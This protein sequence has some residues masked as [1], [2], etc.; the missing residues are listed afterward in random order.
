MVKSRLA[1]GSPTGCPKKNAPINNNS[2]NDNNDNNNNNNDYKNQHYS[3]LVCLFHQY[4]LDTVLAIAGK[5]TVD[6]KLC[7]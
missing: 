4:L 5:C 2:D 6:W 7:D 3:V 1:L